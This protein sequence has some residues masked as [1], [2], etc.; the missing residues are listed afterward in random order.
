MVK[1]EKRLNVQIKEGLVF[2]LKELSIEMTRVNKK[3]VTMQ[4]LGDQAIENLLQEKEN[5]Y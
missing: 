3:T 1:H 2:R 4:S 5:K